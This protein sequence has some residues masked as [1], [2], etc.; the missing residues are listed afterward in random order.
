MENNYSDV[1]STVSPLLNYSLEKNRYTELL[2]TTCNLLSNF[3]SETTFRTKIV[4][5]KNSK[6][7]IFSKIID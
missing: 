5:D 6:N 3:L 2:S 7:L 1:I 4:N